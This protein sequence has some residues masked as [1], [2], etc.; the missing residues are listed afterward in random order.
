ML[1]GESQGA[2]REGLGGEDKIEIVVKK[3]NFFTN[4]NKK[5]EKW[6]K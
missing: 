3:M 1:F 4:L 5:V 6:R 2:L